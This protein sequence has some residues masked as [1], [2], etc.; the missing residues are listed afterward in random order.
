MDS[1]VKSSFCSDMIS[2]TRQHLLFLRRVHAAGESL[3]APSREKIRRYEQI[4][5]PLLLHLQE[6]EVGKNVPLSP[7]IDVAW[8][9]HCH[10]LAPSAY[11]KACSK[12]GINPSGQ[13]P[14][15]AFQCSEEEGNNDNCFTI[16][17]WEKYFPDEPFFSEPVDFDQA[18][19][20]WVA[21]TLIC[22]GRLII[23]QML[24]GSFQRD[25]Y[26][27]VF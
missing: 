14:Q 10:R 24:Y 21:D 13:F 8:L 3:V 11:K 16:S 4:W 1:M 20:P 15:A 2:L 22:E 5:L 12:L 18:C 26:F 25:S 23:Y 9:W 6:N 7:P 19:G 27:T 17:A